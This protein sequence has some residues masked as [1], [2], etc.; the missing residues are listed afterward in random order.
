MNKRTNEMDG[1]FIDDADDLEY[2]V[3]D[4]RTCWRASPTKAIRRQRRYKKKLINVLFNDH[5]I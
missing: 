1:R 4:K 2:L 3:L 5:K